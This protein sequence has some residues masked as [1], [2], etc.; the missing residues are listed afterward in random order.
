MPRPVTAPVRVGLYGKNGHQI[1]RTLERHP[2]A[3]LAA[4]ADFPREELPASLRDDP[5]VR[6]HAS[7]ADLLADPEVDV[8]SLCSARRRDQAA[9][10]IQALRAGKHIYAEKPSAMNEEDLAAVIATAEQ[11]GCLFREMAGTAYEQP[12]RAMRDVVRSGCLGEIV[13]VIAEKSYPYHGNRPPDEDVD[14]GLIEQC[15]IH[16]VRMVEHVA[17]RRIRSLRAVETCAG[18]PGGSS[19]LHM[20]ASMVLTLEGGAVGSISANY[21]NPRGTGTWG[22]ESLR[23]LGSDGMVESA[24]GGQHTRLVLGE[25]DLGPLDLTAPSLD[26]FDIYLDALLGR[27]GMPCTLEEELSPTRWVIRAKHS[28][29]NSL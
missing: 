22:Y 13:Q 5:S 6:F 2:L 20:A 24:R 17:G 23:I 26:Y 3:R 4:V 29:L 10:A 15:A 7:Y 11:T 12:Y 14:G 27:S 9:Q 8:I 19:G 1:H 25:E 21:L 28:A 16:A 18:R